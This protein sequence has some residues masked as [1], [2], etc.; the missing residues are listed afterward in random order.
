MIVAAALI[1]C[2][3]KVDDPEPAADPF[4]YRERCELQRECM[5]DHSTPVE[6]CIAF[7]EGEETTGICPEKYAEMQAC[8]ADLTCAELIDVYDIT[9]GDSS[10]CAFEG[11]EWGKCLAERH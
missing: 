1:A 8:V 5:P 10:L 11:L 3:A 7:H 4:D 9:S 2:A 6:D